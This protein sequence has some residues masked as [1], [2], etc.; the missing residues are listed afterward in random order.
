[1]K[2][3]AIVAA[4]VAIA[5]CDRTTSSR[6]TLIALAPTPV[7]AAQISP[8]TLSLF[9]ATPCPSGTAFTTQFDLV[10]AQTGAR[11]VFID[12]VMLRLI[13]GTGLGGPSVT[14]SQ[15]QL[16]SMFGSTVV[17]STRA[18]P[19]KPQ[20]DCGLT[21]PWSIAGQV[22]LKG[23]EGMTRIVSVDAAFR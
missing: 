22:V 1:M 16:N 12:Q 13:D 20:F 23:A 4:A 10:I 8:Q 14:I 17:G 21:R 19:F 6:G 9:A 18:F 15:P 2:M 11:D 7:I 5:G 3:M